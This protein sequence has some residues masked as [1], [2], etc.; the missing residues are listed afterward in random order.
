M[1]VLFFHLNYLANFLK[2][3]TAFYYF[4]FYL[5]MA[6][7]VFLLPQWSYLFFIWWS[8]CVCSFWYI[9]ALSVSEKCFPKTPLILLGEKVFRSSFFCLTVRSHKALSEWN[10]KRNRRPWVRCHIRW[11][12][13]FRKQIISC[14][15]CFLGMFFFS[16]VVN[17]S[18]GTSTRVCH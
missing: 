8:T 7:T 10:L 13:N 4:I 2:F 3:W 12:G 15:Y 1:L 17:A 14:F 18:T 9:Y 6:E 11:H 16:W 5:L